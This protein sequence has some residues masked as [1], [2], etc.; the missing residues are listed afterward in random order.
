[1]FK[2]GDYVILK[3]GIKLF[4][5][6]DFSYYEG[7]IAKV[8]RIPD[9]TYQKFCVQY[10]HRVYFGNNFEYPEDVRFVKD[11]CAWKGLEDLEKPELKH[12]AQQILKEE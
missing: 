8:I 4:P 7:Q 9:K 12:Y 1:M 5:S 11:Y 10:E 6:E 3:K 2:V